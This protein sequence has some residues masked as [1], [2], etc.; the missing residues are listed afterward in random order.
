MIGGGVL[1]LL[2]FVFIWLIGG[3]SP[4]NAPQDVKVIELSDA[5]HR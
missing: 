4:D 3:A 1:L 2:I 5:S